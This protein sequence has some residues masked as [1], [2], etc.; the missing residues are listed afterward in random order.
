MT[1]VNAAPGSSQPAK[2][3]TIRRCAVLEI[4]RNSVSPCTIP[5][6]MAWNAS[7]SGEH[8]RRPG[9]A[10]APP[11]SAP[12]RCDRSRAAR[13]R[14]AGRRA[15]ARHRARGV[16]RRHRPAGRRSLARRRDED[17]G[18]PEA[19]GLVRRQ[20]RRQPG[21]SARNDSG[22]ASTIPTSTSPTIRPPTGPEPLAVVQCLGLLEHV[23]PQRRLVRPAVLGE[24]DLL[25]AQRLDARARAPPPRPT[26]ARRPG[27]AGGRGW[28][29]TRSRSPRRAPEIAVGSA[30]SDAGRRP[31]IRFARCAR[32]APG[33][34]DVQRPVDAALRRDRPE[35]EQVGEDRAR[36]E[37]RR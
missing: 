12:A 11:P 37:A 3:G 15:V 25:G 30:I 17:V 9:P 23:E 19:T 8:P 31:S 2:A 36:V 34:V 22:S 13:A 26:A 20:R 32:G 18:E 10:V 4:G 35:A 7:T 21:S 33:D 14:G 1:A 6:T 27:R 16:P 28:P 24:A 5:R 29:A